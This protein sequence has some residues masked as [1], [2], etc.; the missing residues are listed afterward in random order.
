M[1]KQ[2]NS[3][4]KNDA[5]IATERTELTFSYKTPRKMTPEIIEIDNEFGDEAG[6]QQRNVFRG[7]KEPAHIGHLLDRQEFEAFDPI[8]N[9]KQHEVE[10][11]LF[12]IVFFLDIS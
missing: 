1:N 8:R 11:W 4:A 7:V 5:A 9:N 3:I 12:T 2:V 10:A 6:G